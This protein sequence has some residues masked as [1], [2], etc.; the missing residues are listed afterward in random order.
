MAMRLSSRISRWTRLPLTTTP[1]RLSSAAAVAIKS[2]TQTER[3]DMT[4]QF[5]ISFA[6][7]ADLEAAIV[8]RSRKACELAEMLNVNSA[9]R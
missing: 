7:G 3:L 5:D 1:E 8:T 6:W 9:V 4:H 2:A